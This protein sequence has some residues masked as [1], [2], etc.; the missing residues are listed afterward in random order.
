MKA[1]SIPT[2]LAVPLLLLFALAGPSA[3]QAAITSSVVAWGENDYGRTTVPVA[4]QSGVTAIAAGISHTVALK[5]DGSV[6]E[7]RLYCCGQTNVPVAPQ[8]GVTAI[9]A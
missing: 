6:V 7:W 9:A 4:A 3:A 5:A 1:N 8:S 2:G